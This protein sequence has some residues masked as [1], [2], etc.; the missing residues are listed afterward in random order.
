MRCRTDPSI[1]MA[2]V[3]VVRSS[4]S[5]YQFDLLFGSVGIVSADAVIGPPRQA[6][7]NK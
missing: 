3:L 7:Y 2:Y 4:C 6:S 1:A 5:T